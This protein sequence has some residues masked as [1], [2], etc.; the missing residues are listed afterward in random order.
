[1]LASRLQFRLVSTEVTDMF[2]YDDDVETLF[3]QASCAFNVT[4]ILG[5]KKGLYLEG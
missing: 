3:N 4:C 2:L 1:M 5:I